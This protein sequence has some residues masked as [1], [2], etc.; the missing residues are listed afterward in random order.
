MTE[1]PAREVLLQY[2]SIMNLF[3]NLAG[4]YQRGARNY[5]GTQNMTMGEVHL[6]MAIEENPGLS[7]NELAGMF[8]CTS[9]A[10]CQLLTRLEKNGYIVR[11][12]DKSAPKRKISFV[13]Q[14]GKQ[15][16]K[17]HENFDVEMMSEIHD[18]LTK[19]CSGEDISNF[20][21]VMRVYNEYLLSIRKKK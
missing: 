7:G 8:F 4:E 14:K 9:S 15:L 21:R 16:C 19:K 12:A 20:Y 2:E 1:H 13:T 18:W 5:G 3:L 6:L 11:T 17:E 10:I